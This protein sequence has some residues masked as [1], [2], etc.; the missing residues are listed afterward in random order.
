MSTRLI[1]CTL[2]QFSYT[3]FS[4][5]FLFTGPYVHT[6][7]SHVH[8]C[9]TKLYNDYPIKDVFLC[10]TC[11]YVTYI[12]TCNPTHLCTIQ[13]CDRRDPHGR[14]L[15]LGFP[16]LLCDGSEMAQVHCS[17]SPTTSK[18][19]SFHR[20][21]SPTTSEVLSFH[22]SRSPTTS[23]VLSLHHNKSPTT[24][25]VLSFH[26][27]RSPTTSE[28]LSL[29]RS[30]SL[31]HQ[32]CSHFTAA[33]PYHIKGAL[34]SLQQ[35]PYHIKG[36]LTSPQQIPYHIKGALTSPQQIPTTSKVL[37]FHCSRSLPHQR[38]SHFT[39]ADPYHIRG[40]LTSPQQIPTTSK[41][42]SF[43]CSRSLPHQRSSHFTAAD[44]LPH[45]RSSH[46]TAADPYH[47]RGALISPQ[48]IPTTSEELSFHR[49]R[50]PT[51]SEEL[52][53][54]CSRSLPHQRSSH[55]TAADPL[56]HQRCSHFRDSFGGHTLKC[57]ST[58]STHLTISINFL[59]DPLL[60]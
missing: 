53:F 22:C 41:V 27:S 21:I 59:P 50:S 14:N 46:F 44:P 19:L 26:C 13:F 10:V 40:A 7:G 12:H 38:C 52:S 6:R 28:E 3:I 34:I 29:H 58:S 56:P 49:S 47:I 37:S 60:H 31:P 42:L 55:F 1:Q 4:V 25:K 5:Y 30:R 48:Q 23:K 32:R 20:S 24:S 39:A 11:P 35:I 57:T 2:K 9:T 43:H 33:D 36:A 8:Y 17:R 18:V 16:S 45:Q 51:T 15:S 54:H